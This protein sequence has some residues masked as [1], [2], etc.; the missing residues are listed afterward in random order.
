MLSIGFASSALIYTVAVI[1]VY[2]AYQIGRNAAQIASITPTYSILIVILAAIFL[3]ERDRLPRK[4]S[5]AT[6]AII[7]IFLLK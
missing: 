7:G 2:A 1:T 5:A 3:N 6:L 4:L